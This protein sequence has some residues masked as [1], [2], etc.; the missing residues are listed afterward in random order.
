MLQTH[1]DTLLF[2]SNLQ[3]H[4][5]LQVSEYGPGNLSLNN[6]GYVG[7]NFLHF[8]QKCHLSLIPAYVHT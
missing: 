7:I 5:L 3:C 1:L 8:T 6:H 4:K 2:C